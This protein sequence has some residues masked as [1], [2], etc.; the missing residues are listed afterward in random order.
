M[1]EGRMARNAGQPDAAIFSNG[2]RP[3]ARY[4]AVVAVVDHRVVAALAAG[5]SGLRMAR[6]AMRQIGGQTGDVLGGAEQVSETAILV[7]LAARLAQ[8]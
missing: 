4:R 1:R 6:L 7:L 5:L 8:P 2:G 3:R